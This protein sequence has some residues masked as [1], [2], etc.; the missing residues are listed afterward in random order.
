MSNRTNLA[1]V[2]VFCISK[3]SFRLK[4]L[5]FVWELL[6]YEI[7]R[8]QDLS[9]EKRKAKGLEEQR[10]KELARLKEPQESM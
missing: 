3:L 2:F 4:N 1:V 5:F 10:R 7:K 8:R 9:E 6:R